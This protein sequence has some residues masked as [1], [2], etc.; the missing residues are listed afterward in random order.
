M[1][2]ESELRLHTSAF[3]LSV[4]KRSD[5]LMNYF[6]PGFFLTG[7][8][9]AFFYDTWLIAFGVGG[10]SLLAYYSVKLLLPDSELYQ[11]VLSAVLAIFM[12]QYIY[13]MHG[14]FEM[15]F[16][17]FIGSAILITYQNWK[18]QI[19][20]LVLVLIHHA[21]LGYLQNIG[22]DKVYFTQLDYFALQAYVIHILLSAVIFFT[23]GLWGYQL[24][25]YSE[26][27]IGQVI[28]MGRI[29]Q[30]AALAADAQKKE[31]EQQAAVLDKAV[32]QGKFDMASDVLHDIGNAV[33]G[34]GSY[35]TR[36]RR[37]QDQ[38]KPENLQNL[39]VFFEDQHPVMASALG[40]ARANAL[41]TM[42]NGIAETQKINQ[43]EIANSITEQL[44][45]INQIQEILHIQRQYINGQETQER[46][47]VNLRHVINDCVSM[48]FT[49]LDK[50]AIAVSLFMPEELPAIKG[51]RTRLMQVI[52]NLLKNCIESIDQQAREKSISLGV[53][54]E[55]GLLVVK[56]KDS[57]HGLEPA[58]AG[59]LFERGFTTKPSGTGIGLYNCRAI[60]ESHAGTIVLTSE[61]PGMGSLAT[62]QFKI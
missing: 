51:D 42:L 5:K 48:L 32:A 6:L 62:I 29:Q 16:F 60:V 21:S 27:Q 14:L 17:A 58:T 50:S 30:E 35:L 9:L 49:A 13:Q 36:I 22:F 1:Q 3:R 56:V 53:H 18:L 33:V 31:Q 2:K 34:F 59:R 46:K 7:L 15:H 19:P 28:E 40:E 61:G 20:M 47:P 8:A 54:T 25:K 39:A 23:C 12:A 24:K 55:D 44:S 41:V 43:E 11:Y 4:K 45:I 37:M 26:I 10:F 38:E 57:G 52:L